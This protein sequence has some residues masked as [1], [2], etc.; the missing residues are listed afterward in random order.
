MKMKSEHY[1]D[2]NEND[3]FG[4]WFDDLDAV[5][6]TKVTTAIIRMENGNFS[7]VAPVGEGVSEKKINYGKGLRIYF[8]KDGDRLIILLNGGT[9]QRQQKDI[10]KAIK[11]WNNY[12]LRKKGKKQ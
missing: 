1:I 9:K 10:E 5:T 2:D 3:P 12:K 6:A 7:D 8:A 11:N 4:D